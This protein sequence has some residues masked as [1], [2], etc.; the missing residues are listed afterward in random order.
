MNN[1]ILRLKLL[2][3]LLLVY[4]TSISAAPF[5]VD[6]L[7]YE[8]INDN[9]VRLVKN[10][11]ETYKGDIIIPSSIEYDG[12]SY[13][14]TLIESF[15]F[16]DCG[17]LK[18]VLIPNSV[19][20]IGGSCFKNCYLLETIKMS[21]QIS[22]IENNTFENCESLLSISIPNS[23]K[24]I[25][26]F[27]FLGCKRLKEVIFGTSVRI[28][29]SKAFKA[30]T[31]LAAITI[32]KSV[33][34]LYMS[35]FEDCTM[36]TMTIEDGSEPLKI[37][38]TDHPAIV[39]ELYLGRNQPKSGGRYF[40][41][42]DLERLTISS[43][44]TEISDFCFYHAGYF[45][46][47]II[48]NS[49]ERICYSAFEGCNIKKLVIGK[50]VREI[51]N[52]AFSSHISDVTSLN[53]I[54]PKVQRNTFVDD[55]SSVLRVPKGSVD[56]YKN[57][58]FWNFGNIVEIDSILPETT[59]YTLTITAT[60]DG[61]VSYNDVSV[62]NDT[63]S[64]SI[65]KGVKAVVKFHPGEGYQIKSATM[66]GRQI[67]DLSSMSF[68]IGSMDENV[69]IAVEYEPI[70]P[71][72]SGKYLTFVAEES[73]TFN[74]F[75]SGSVKYSLNNGKT[76]RDLP[77]N[78]STPMVSAGSK[79]LW[80][81]IN[82]PSSLSGIGTFS[83]SGRFNVEGNISSLLF[84]DD[85]EGNK[86]KGDW[87]FW[88]LFYNCTNLVSAENLVIPAITSSYCYASMFEGCTSLTTAPKLPATTLDSYC[89]TDMFF[90]C[91]SLTTAPELPATTLD[92]CCYKAMFAYCTSLTTAPELPAT[93]LAYRCYYQMFFDCTSLTTAPQ[94]PATTLAKEC[95][96][97]MFSDCTS[98]TT[99][100]SVLPATTLASHC[101]DAMFG[102]CTSLT[103]APELPA[104]TLASYC[105]HDMF[106]NCTSLTTAPQLP[107]TKLAEGCYY[108]MFNGCTSL[109]YIKCLAK[110]SAY[111]STYNWVSGVASSG[112][113]IK[114]SSM[115]SWTKGKNG[116][117]SGWTVQNMPNIITYTLTITSTG[118][119]YVSYNDISVENDTQSISIEEGVTAV[120][121]FHPSEGC[122]IKS[123]TMNGRQIADLSS[124][125]FTIDSMD[126]DITI[127]VEYEPIS[128]TPSTGDLNGDGN[129]DSA[130][131]KEI[132]NYIMGNPSPN[133]D[134]NEADI[135]NDG[136][137]N[138]ADMVIIINR[139]KN[140]SDE[141]D[142]SGNYL[143]F[144][145]SE[146]G[147][148][149]FTKNVQY[150]IDNG[151]TWTT[152]A[153]NTDTPTVQ[154]GQKI[155]WK[156][157]LVPSGDGIG[158][159][160]SSKQ[161]TVEG[162]TM[163]L[164]YSD[165]FIGQ[166]SLSGNEF[167]FYHLFAG[168]IKLISAEKLS[169]PATTLASNCYTG[170]FRNCSSLTTA[171]QLPA[172]TL[173]NQCYHLMFEGCTSLTTAPSLPATTLASRC[174]EW[175][176]EGCTSL[177]AAP[178][179]PATTLASHCYAYM[180]T[181]CTSLV[182]APELPATTLTT[183]CYVD[184]FQ[185][186]TSL[187]TA[188]ELPAT[189]LAKWC[190]GWMFEGC[191]SLTAAPELPATTLA[192]GCYQ[193]M[194]EGCTSLTTAPEL[195]ATTLTT[196]CYQHMFEGCTNL[197][198]APE[199]PATALTASCYYHMF[200]GCTS[201]TTAPV[202]P[203]TTLAAASYNYMF[204]GC[205]SLNYIKCLAT[206]ISAQYCTKD[207]VKGVASSGTFVKAS[208]MNSWTIGNYGIPPGWT[209]CDTESGT[210]NS[211][212]DN[213]QPGGN[214]E[215][216]N[217][218]TSGNYLTFVALEDGTFCFKTYS[219]PVSYSLDGGSTWSSLDSDVNSP[220]V[221]AGQRIM[222]KGNLTPSGKE[223]VWGVGKFSSTG[224]FNVE[225]NAMSLL[226]GDNFEGQI[227]L[228][229]K[230]C[231][232]AY[233]FNGN[234]NIV[235]AKNLVLPATI[236]TT[237]CY[238]GMFSHCTSL[239]EAP[240]LPA[241]TLAEQCYSDMFNGCT[242]LTKA[243]E[244]PATT[245]VKYCYQQMFD[246]CTSLTTPPKLPATTL[247]YACYSFMFSNC[248]SLTTLP[249]LPATTLADFCYN[250]MFTGC[251][252][253]ANI[254]NDLLPATTLAR[255]CY[256][257]MFLNCTS[258]TTV[259]KLPATT[260]AYNCYNAMFSFCTSLTTAP[261]LP[262]TTLV[263]GC[264]EHMF[265]GSSKLNYIKCLATDISAENCTNEWL[266][267]VSTAGTF[268]KASSMN[269]WTTGN[270]GIPSGWTVYNE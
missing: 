158:T 259:P 185:N 261:E 260:L 110:Q 249:Q 269:S 122:Q 268:V 64:I 78:R 132:E 22:N 53:P 211:D 201:L 246:N 61:Y 9:E 172:T 67:A 106:V 215:G 5:E 119:G 131:I 248:T 203:A 243:P 229:G 124:M 84:G 135:N 28:I 197:T 206:S 108:D 254:P 264:Y 14:V 7:S 93:T 133:F 236:L 192:E 176:F 59:T 188:P 95:Y 89:Y 221:S 153:K 198:T 267:I 220:L 54:P 156:G 8:I 263:E 129:I 265:R 247:A 233:L 244:L 1:I 157:N 42:M 17:H 62:E 162:N 252:S 180:F 32:P 114:A 225:G 103:T 105:Y 94:L 60:G 50:N 34:T 186:C 76:W 238:M 237:A 212:N 256:Y 193:Y 217:S 170:M 25:E 216:S 169:L 99:P 146:S 134:V 63:Q 128:P 65:E 88:R 219:T 196:S 43:S 232:L 245:L 36:N 207:W 97:V 112:T 241:T 183:S 255:C 148:F 109:N 231:A 152:L 242:S 205:T 171:P 174:Y 223:A 143:T 266:T 191:T 90:N 187:T 139:I 47:V 29:D 227:D 165:N 224:R 195:P 175:M 210:T 168:C 86:L 270:N 138:V 70:P 147:T 74:F 92:D 160:S 234:A 202:L 33:E 253:L 27:A 26:N 190:Y 173:A 12:I 250:F 184:M 142:K 100:P 177:T 200:R 140:N 91:T 181:G 126:K 19:T 117:P 121:K 149:R 230:K 40:C 31:S 51:E 151:S 73:G 159:F 167:V 251:T 204:S 58:K 49:V 208:S 127:T 41:G 179:L 155:M 68:T 3:T 48:P 35:A 182:K 72:P 38:E 11:Y 18:S 4:S 83:S 71:N 166:T 87:T 69:T 145:A 23:V 123:A 226:H 120:V 239:T 115:T 189:T 214:N 178:Q 46:K 96:C 45:D 37:I 154:A 125:S 81:G 213:P 56:A 113:F 164:L 21:D 107:A 98:L 13:K 235:S 111:V 10:K 57:D 30:C 75:G 82:Y 141:D 136:V 258:L 52:L 262:A 218:D 150:S 118:E 163:S 101:Y 222:W 44:V 77:G 240:E 116:I 2:L 194:F 16:L 79:I 144:V 130:D 209:V 6:G 137:V 66:N 228:T 161:F 102:G 15:A 39:K 104:T 80:K 20:R 257:A 85:F 24:K 199:L 55:F